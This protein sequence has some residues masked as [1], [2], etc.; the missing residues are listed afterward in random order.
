MESGQARRAAPA[1]P[2]RSTAIERTAPE[3]YPL[4]HDYH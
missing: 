4:I 3:T 2:G 1:Q